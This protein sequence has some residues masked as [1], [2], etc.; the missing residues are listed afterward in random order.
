MKPIPQISRLVIGVL[1]VVW[2]CSS[3]LAAEDTARPFNADRF[4]GKL[5]TELS[6]F[7]SSASGDTSQMQTRRAMARPQENFAFLSLKIAGYLAGIL[8]LIVLFAWIAKKGGLAG[9]SKL[10]GTGSM[11][12]LEALPLGNAKSIALVRIMDAV[13]IVG[14]TQQSISLLDKIEGEKAVEII[15]SSKG[16][17]SMAK[18]KD[19]FSN[20]MGKM[21]KS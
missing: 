7:D 1:S 6:Q 14:Q 15:A 9:S 5:H 11:D 12:I 4:M 18:F 20:F 13:Y 16:G 8:V 19:V 10:G 2:L 3:S 17:V 21:K